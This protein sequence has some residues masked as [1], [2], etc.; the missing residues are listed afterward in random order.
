MMDEADDNDVN[1]V[2]DVYDV[3]FNVDFHAWFL[4]RNAEYKEAVTQ[5]LSGPGVWCMI[6]ERYGE[7]EATIRFK[8]MTGRRV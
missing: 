1:D 7:D 4:K 3:N 5:Q 8:S 6:Y 2:N